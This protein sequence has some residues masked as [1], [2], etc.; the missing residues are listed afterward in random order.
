MR[1]LELTEKKIL[2][3]FS[4]DPYLV[5]AIKQIPNRKWE[6]ASKSW[7]FPIE[8]DLTPIYGFAAE[9]KF[10]IPNEFRQ[11]FIKRQELKR[12]NF[13]NSNKA[14]IEKEKEFT[15]EGLKMQ[16]YPYQLAGIEY[17]IKNNKA[18]LGDEMGLGKSIQAIATIKHLGKRA[19]ITCPASLKYNWY[20]EIK[21]WTNMKVCVLDTSRNRTIINADIYI[22]NYDILEK[23]SDIIEKLNIE[24]FVFDE[25]QY[26]KNAKTKRVEAVKAMIKG[27][28]YIYMLTG[29]II[30]NRTNELI[31][32][33]TLLGKLDALGGYWYF[34]SRYCGMTKSKFG[35]EMKGNT[36]SQELNKKIRELCYIRRNKKDVLKELPDK[37]RVVIEM[38]IDNPK[39]YSLAESDL[40]SYLSSKNSQ[41]T[42]NHLTKIEILKQLAAKG[43]LKQF[44]EWIEIF[45]E[46]GEK[47][48]VFAHHK[49]IIDILQ[50][51]FKCRKIDGSVP[52]EQRQAI[53]TDFQENES[54]K[55]LILSIK[56]A[57]VGLNLT[58]A[59]N[60]AF[61]EQGWTPGE[62]EQ[63]ED[64]VLRIGQ[65]NAVTCYY[66]IDKETIDIDIYNIIN[67]KRK[68]TTVINAG[69]EFE[70][71]YNA[72]VLEDLLKLF[73]TKKSKK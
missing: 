51:H 16:P 35:I 10:D 69:K 58:A 59:S 70:G 55:L 36:N 71:T 52:S 60:V 38:T 24:V 61:I 40:V 63:C 17:L 50:K 42:A 1:T 49:E 8:T 46:S 20:A 41:T 54:S 33:L 45:I 4:Y 26:L 31:T 48:L 5:E 9:H 18:I 7:S 29:T 32:P 39:D 43:K 12:E 47:L 72:S 34:A 2:L 3:K 66:F 23:M 13:F 68:V 19:L 15:I 65:K 21:K 11:I 37:T 28:S 27:K 6:A 44:I 53:V 25:S 73:K 64:R 30:T 14:E 57:G 56:A 62:H 67:D 22:I